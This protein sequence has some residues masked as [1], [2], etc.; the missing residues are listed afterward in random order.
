MATIQDLRERFPNYWRQ[1]SGS[2]VVVCD[3]AQRLSFFSTLE[4]AR[5]AKVCSCG[6]NCDRYQSPHY[7]IKLEAAPSAQ[8]AKVSRAWRLMVEAE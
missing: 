1:G 2:F 8:P 5:A 4:V 7:G 6:R 3:S